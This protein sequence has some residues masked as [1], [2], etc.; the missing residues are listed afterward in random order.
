MKNYFIQWLFIG[1]LCMSA[2]FANAQTTQSDVLYRLDRTTLNVKVVEITSLDVFY[3]DSSTPSA[4]QKIAKAQLWKVVFA[5]GSSDVYN[6]PKSGLETGPSKTGTKTHPPISR[7][8]I[9]PTE[10]IDNPQSIIK[11]APL[12]NFGYERVLA[13]NRSIYAG[14]SLYS[15]NAYVTRVTAIGLKGEYRFYGLIKSS[16]K[17]A[18][19]G[20]WV[21]PTA[22][23]WNVTVKESGFFS[24]GDSYS[25]SVFVSQ[26]GGIAG[27]QWVFN[28]KISLEPALGLSVTAVGGGT[29]S[30]LGA[31]VVPLLALRVGYVLK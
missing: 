6:V 23:L 12:T 17:Q 22:L 30:I 26:L 13:N 29:D 25:E 9:Q 2:G 19:E 7:P 5:D 8:T 14:I 16:P 10:S 27:Y 24:Y 28:R 31:G 15:V 18:P 1:C 20:F 4:T 11:Y 21:A 3:R